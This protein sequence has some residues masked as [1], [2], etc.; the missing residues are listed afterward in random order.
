[1]HVAREPAV[2]VNR[3]GMHTPYPRSFE[4][5]VH[6]I[7]PLSGSFVNVAVNRFGKWVVLR[8]IHAVT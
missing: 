2:G 3:H 7:C 4:S 6:R 8:W 1:V 5:N